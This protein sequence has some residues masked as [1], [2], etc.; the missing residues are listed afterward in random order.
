MN[1]SFINCLSK[2]VA[3]YEFGSD[4]LPAMLMIH[5]NSVHAGFLKPLI[6][7]LEPKY[8]IIT[9][10]LPGHNQSAAWEKRII[11]ERILPMLF[12][13]FHKIKINIAIRSLRLRIPIKLHCLSARFLLISIF[14]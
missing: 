2:P 9:L 5:G 7:L 8:H 4:T 3:L 1:P 10:D 6:S 13:I 11:T 14:V 12:V